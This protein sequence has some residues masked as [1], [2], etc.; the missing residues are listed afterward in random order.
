MRAIGSLALAGVVACLAFQ[1]RAAAPTACTGTFSNG[2]AINVAKAANMVDVGYVSKTVT[3]QAIPVGSQTP[4]DVHSFAW[5]QFLYLTQSDPKT[6]GTPRFLQFAPWYNALTLGPK[7]AA[8]PGGSTALQTA[9]IDLNQAQA[10]SAGHLLDVQNQTVRYDIRFDQ[11]MYSSIVDQNLYTAG[12]YAAKCNPDPATNKCK[13]NNIWMIP[14]GANESPEPGATELKTAWRDFGSA[15]NCPSAQFYCNGRFA[16][17]GFHFVNKTF[18]HGEWIWASF[19]HVAN[20]PDCAPGGDTTIA[21]K[22]PINTAWSFFNPATVPSSVMS[23]K[24][25]NVTSSPPQCNANPNP[26]G[27]GSSWVAVN[28]CRTDK[29]AA[30]GTSAAN[31]TIGPANSAGNVACLNATIL[32]QRSGVWRNY[33]LVGAVWAQGGI[34]PNVDFRIQGFQ[35]QTNPPVAYLTPVGFVHLANTTIETWL[36]NGATGYDPLKANGTKAG[37]FFC[38]NEP[39]SRSQA[40]LSHFPGKL[41]LLQALRNS[42]LGANSTAKAS[43]AD[44]IAAAAKKKKSH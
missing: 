20:A 28:V 19:E 31:C 40:D 18:S 4:C 8:Y 43:N 39:S 17:V 44:P 1:A 21:P 24:T 32:P 9:F 30:G 35:S 16:L 22:S 12:L 2:T 3:P 10:G 26:S 33:K 23:S 42:L 6:P 25:C 34:G 36:Q 38:H 29:I 11:Y 13:N 14:I 41:P 15:A 37:C 7:P 5:N 27:D